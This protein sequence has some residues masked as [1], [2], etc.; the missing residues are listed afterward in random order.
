L[1][2][3]LTAAGLYVDHDAA[4]EAFRS[5]GQFNAIDP[6]SGWKADLIF[7]KAR[8][9]S[10]TE[11]ARRQPSELFGIEI[12]LTTVEDLIIAKLEWSELGDS[13]LQRRDIRQLIEL[14]GDRIDEAYLDH[15]ISELGLQQAWSRV[16]STG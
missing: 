6:S 16:G 10:T 5:G 13:E 1:V 15:W 14:A 7:R 2:A 9:F 12:T 11:F 4:L 8:P 3:K